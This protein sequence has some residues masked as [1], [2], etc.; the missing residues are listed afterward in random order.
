MHTSILLFYLQDIINR[1]ELNALMKY[2]NVKFER[3]F[4][5]KPNVQSPNEPNTSANH[6]V[7]RKE[8]VSRDDIQVNSLTIIFNFLNLP[9][10]CCFR[11]ID[12]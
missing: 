2:E 9:I 3:N 5:M 12:S 11:Q 6:S 1:S 8:E 10:T 7:P 4:E